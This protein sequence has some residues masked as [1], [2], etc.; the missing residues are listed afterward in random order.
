MTRIDGETQRRIQTLMDSGNFSDVSEV[1]AEAV[2]GLANQSRAD[3]D[4]LRQLIQ[5]GWLQA[6]RGESRPFTP[7]VST[8]LW[9][10]ARLRNRRRND[11]DARVCS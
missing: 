11:S 5:V 2:E 10:E 9:E 3:L 1:L 4:H 7:E 8:E 6:E